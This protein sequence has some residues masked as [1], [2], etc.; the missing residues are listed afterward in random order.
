MHSLSACPDV[1]FAAEACA[2]I[3]AGGSMPIINL[4][5]RARINL[6][7]TRSHGVNYRM[8]WW[9]E[10]LGNNQWSEER[11]RPIQIANATM[12][13]CK[14]GRGPAQ[15]R[16]TWQHTYSHIAL[17]TLGAVVRANDSRCGVRKHGQVERIKQDCGDL[18][19]AECQVYI[20]PSV[21][22]SSR[23]CAGTAGG[24]RP[25]VRRK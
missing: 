20:P 15:Y 21:A 16:S 11:Q 4:V 14:F 13:S 12:A 1:Y 5:S 24:W 25:G 3:D 22:G 18:F 17:D 9:R 8:T 2:Y 19:N 10:K 23:M 6:R 7:A